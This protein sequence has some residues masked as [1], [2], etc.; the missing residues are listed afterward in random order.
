LIPKYEESGV[1]PP[2][3]GE[4]PAY[5]AAQAPYKV[6]LNE[7]VTHFATSEERIAI[8][9][10]FLGYRTKF[11]A[12]GMINGFQWIDGSFVENVE[13]NRG[14]APNDI[15]LVSFA[16]KPIGL[17]RADVLG[18]MNTNKDIFSPIKAKETYKCDAYFVDLDLPTKAIV[19]KTKYWF[20][21][22]SHQRDTSLWKG[23]LEIDLIDDENAAL[24]LLGNGGSDAS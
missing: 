9:R 8:L 24:E 20:G 22:F 7:F 17:N 4:S 16:H 5:S 14:R 15:D 13:K 11:K 10:G 1:L 19:S 21:L 18:F 23:M 3:I 12:L 6:S 2:F